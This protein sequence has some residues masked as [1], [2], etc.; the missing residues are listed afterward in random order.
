MRMSLRFPVA[1]S[2]SDF[3][4]SK[5]L[6]IEKMRLETAIEGKK[7]ERSICEPP[8]NQNGHPPTKKNQKKRPP[9]PLARTRTPPAPLSVRLPSPLATPLPHHISMVQLR[10]R[11]RPAGRGVKSIA[12]LLMLFFGGS[13]LGLLAHSMEPR[14]VADAL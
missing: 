11:G 6:D 5:T 9:H 14:R 7:P 8:V 1:R 3:A 12:E 10:T 2:V 4:S 13:F